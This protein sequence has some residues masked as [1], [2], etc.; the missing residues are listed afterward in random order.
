MHHKQPNGDWRPDFTHAIGVAADGLE[1][2]EMWLTQKIARGHKP[3]ATQKAVVAESL[4][5]IAEAR[6]LLTGL[7][8]ETLIELRAAAHADN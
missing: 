7:G 8:A 2:A 5:H 3:D 6:G 1:Q 4:A